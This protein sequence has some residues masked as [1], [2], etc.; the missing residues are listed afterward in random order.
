MTSDPIQELLQFAHLKISYELGFRTEKP[1]LSE[2]IAVQSLNY[3][4]KKSRK[5]VDIKDREK[6]LF[7]CAIIWENK[8][9]GWNNVDPFIAHILFRIGLIPSAIMIFWNK[10]E[11]RFGSF[12]SLVDD[13]FLSAHLN[14]HSIKIK[15]KEY[16][17][18]DFQ[19]EVWESIDKYN[20]SGI[21]APTSA[22]KSF[23]LLLKIADT[24]LNSDTAQVIY[25]VPTIS[26][27]NQV[28]S[29][30]KDLFSKFGMH[31]ET[32]QTISH[33]NIQTKKC[34]YVLTQERALSAIQNKVLLKHLKLLVIDELQNV[35]K[36]GIE[37]EERSKILFDV[38]QEFYTNI[39]P[40][41]IVLSG[42]RLKNVKDLTEKWFEESS[43][44]TVDV[45]PPVLNL[46][47]SFFADKKNVYFKQSNSLK[48]DNVIR[49]ADRFHLENKI[50]GKK[51]YAEDV[52]RFMVYLLNRFT[53]K[54]S[55]II[56]SKSSK[57]SAKTAKAISEFMPE[58]D[59]QPH[60]IE[61]QKYIEETIHP[62]YGL[63][64]TLSKN[65][66]Y[67][68][69]KMPL[70]IR[71]C[72]EKALKE[73]LIRNVVC[74]T[75]LMQGINLPIKNLIVRNPT[76]GKD[77]DL[78]GYDFSNLKGR[79]G[80]LMHEFI[81]RVIIIDDK[82]FSESDIKLNEFQEKE[83][84]GT[85]EEEFE[86][87][88]Q[89]IIK[90]LKE[91]NPVNEDSPYNH[92]TVYTRNLILKHGS[93]A[94]EVL[95]KR[96]INIPDLEIQE[97]F[98]KLSQIDIP[99]EIVLKNPYWDPLDLNSL[100][101][102]INK[103][104]LIPSEPSQLAGILEEVLT[105]LQTMTPHYYKKYFN[106]YN[107]KRIK[108]ICIMAQGWAKGKKLREIIDWN[109]NVAEKDEII[110][111]HIST[112]LKEVCFDIPKLLKPV[113]E[114]QNPDNP[115]LTYLEAGA[116]D[117]KLRGLIGKGIHR[118]TAIRLLEHFKDGDFLTNDDEIAEIG[119]S[120]FIKK[121]RDS[122]RLNIWDKKLIEGT[123]Y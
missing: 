13:L 61:L 70:H 72:I 103:L 47:Y 89:N 77:T 74:T 24:L 22:G 92:L 20:T 11:G 112:I 3:A 27:I 76:I 84:K 95:S 45:S 31:I 33:K 41:K 110:E 43:S 54:E 122:S 83:I 64:K 60:I 15:S 111:G 50:L 59:I 81:G 66:A 119:F 9:E 99:K 42:A 39:K 73:D 14:T 113:I 68:H 21:S 55:T 57:Q 78:T 18:S 34:V 80:R 23:I 123:S 5:I 65:I 86:K 2:K 36:V 7:I 12:N 40:E 58:V 88:K 19:K 120:E 38:I 53:K 46:T 109:L 32:L 56:F 101:R 98:R 79:A 114:I 8:E 75:T 102:N 28:S 87:H 35:E 100:Y 26:L 1:T 108:S 10:K 121:A 25:I 106:E 71:A 44:S 29:D 48:I 91:S 118:E 90:D 67:H 49:I 37:D 30:L 62:E 96:G 105:R 16:F 6:C 115:I 104:P 52:H 117:P 85:F 51:R 97:I 82:A 116:F 63:K 107:K 4:E 93:N 94:K 69:G 17:L